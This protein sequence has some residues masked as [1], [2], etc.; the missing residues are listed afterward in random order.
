MVIV[1]D[2]A[3]EQP[4]DFSKVSKHPYE[5]NLLGFV[6]QNSFLKHGLKL[7]VTWVMK[8]KMN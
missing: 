8:C 5:I 3:D 2:S 4:K 7:R 1:K 6:P